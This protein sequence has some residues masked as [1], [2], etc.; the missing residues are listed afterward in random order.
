MATRVSPIPYASHWQLNSSGPAGGSGHTHHR[1][2][3][4]CLEPPG[5]GRY[6]CDRHRGLVG[7]VEVQGIDRHEAGKFRLWRV[8]RVMHAVRRRRGRR[9]WGWRFA[10]EAH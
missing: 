9:F 4:E 7:P 2:S 10:E 3:W 5:I 1:K 8:P 6:P